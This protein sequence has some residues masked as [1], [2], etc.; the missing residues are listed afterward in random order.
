MRCSGGTSG[1]FPCAMPFTLSCGWRALDRTGFA[2]AP[3]NT[4]FKRG[5][6]YRSLAMRSPRSNRLFH[7]VRRTLHAFPDGKNLTKG[8]REG[9]TIDNE[10][11]GW[12]Q[13]FLQA[14][15]ETGAS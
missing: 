14:V 6:W 2:G 4:R 11:F 13:D 5:E 7:S 1:S 15:A 10:N 12:Y 9:F 8:C 3:L